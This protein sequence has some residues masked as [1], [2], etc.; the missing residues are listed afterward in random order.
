MIAPVIVVATMLLGLGGATGPANAKVPGPNGRIV[1]ERFD[2]TLRDT[3][4]YTVNPDGSHAQ[5]LIARPSKDGGF[6]HWSPDGSEVSIFCCA[7]EW[8]P[9][10][11]MPTP[12][13]S[14][15]SR[16]RTPPSR[17]TAASPGLPTAR[18]SPAAPSA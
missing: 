16:Q 5:E 7:D 14:A 3:V 15:S 10:S 12:A 9:T 13:A 17:T 8:L 11:S 18:G 1:F 6:P 2:P 4:P